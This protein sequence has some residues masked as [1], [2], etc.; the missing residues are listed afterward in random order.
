[1]QRVVASATAT[2]VERVV[3]DGTRR[4]VAE[5]LVNGVTGAASNCK[6]DDDADNNADRRG[7]AEADADVHSDVIK[8]GANVRDLVA[9]ATGD[10]ALADVASAARRVADRIGEAATAVRDTSRQVAEVVHVWRARD[11]RPD[12]A[13]GRVTS[14]G[15]ARIPR[16]ADGVLCGVQ[17]AINRV[18]AI[19]RAGE[20]V[21]AVLGRG[22]AGAGAGV[23]DRCHARRARAGDRGEHAVAAC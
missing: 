2:S 16:G 1:M 5:A 23:T 9:D 10:V 22:A 3:L 4:A 21:V 12:A 11:R 8:G 19:N 13:L 7:D 18:A 17:A 14:A 6:E 20:T 15:L